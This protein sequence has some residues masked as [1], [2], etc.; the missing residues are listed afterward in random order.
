[1]RAPWGKLGAL[2]QKINPLGAA[3][4]AANHNHAKHPSEPGGAFGKL[5]QG[6]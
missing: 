1:M 3:A 6:A 4:A 5:D 2:S